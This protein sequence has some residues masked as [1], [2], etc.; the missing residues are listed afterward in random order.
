MINF[1]DLDIDAIADAYWNASGYVDPS[2]YPLSPMD[3]NNN[4]LDLGLAKLFNDSDSGD[5]DGSVLPI[6]HLCLSS[7]MPLDCSDN[8]LLTTCCNQLDPGLRAL[9][10]LDV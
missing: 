4:E 2:W 8:V 6:N 1:D 7:S 9:H 3:D 10:A 5:D